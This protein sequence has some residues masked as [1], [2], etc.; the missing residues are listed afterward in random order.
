MIRELERKYY[1]KNG[2][3]KYF[4]ECNNVSAKNINIT[5][6]IRNKNDISI[7]RAVIENVSVSVSS[8]SSQNKNI[9]VKIGPENRTVRKEYFYSNT[10]HENKIPGFIKYTCIFSCYDDTIINKDID[11]ICTAKPDKDLYKDV[12]IMPYL[13]E[14]SVKNH[15]WKDNEFPVLKSLLLQSIFSLF[16]AYHEIGFLHN[17]LHFDNIL[18]KKTSK[19]SIKY[20]Y[21]DREYEIPTYGYMAIILDF[22]S[23][24]MTQ[25]QNHQFY[26]SNLYNLLSRVNSDLTNKDGDLVNMLSNSEIIRFIDEQKNKNRNYENVFHIFGMIT[27]S[28]FEFIKKP[29]YVYDPNIYG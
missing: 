25:K 21:N 24:M 4:I 23:S 15:S 7:L 2:G 29:S 12:L 20:K 3:N 22:D 10:L 13:Q 9:V 8:S 28:E 11:R 1:K 26:W 5:E 17:D 19:T 18:M 16:L 27:D 6:R 14:G